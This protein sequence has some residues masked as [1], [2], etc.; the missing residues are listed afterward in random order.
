MTSW[1]EE[2]VPTVSFSMRNFGKVTVSDFDVNHD[3]LLL[4]DSLFTHATAAQVL[5]QIHDS[6][7]GAV[8]VVDPHDSITLT[9]VTVAQLQSNLSDFHFF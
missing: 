7:A 5:S 2:P 3:A 8:V 9:G 1:R 4:D 6:A